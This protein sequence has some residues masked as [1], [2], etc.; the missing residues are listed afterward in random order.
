MSRTEFCDGVIE[1]LT[2]SVQ[3]IA[4]VLLLF[5]TIDPSSSFIQ[6]ALA[7]QAEILQRIGAL[8]F[9]WRSLMTGIQ[10][11]PMCTR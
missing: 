8:S 7:G 11:G 9:Q 5:E 1:S 10:D 4:L 2:G 3:R 6:F